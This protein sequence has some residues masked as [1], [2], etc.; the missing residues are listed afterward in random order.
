M[1]DTIYCNISFVGAEALRNDLGE[2]GDDCIISQVV[3]YPWDQNIPLLVEYTE[4]MNRHQPQANIGFVSLEGYMVGK[5]FCMVVEKVDGEL[6]R[7]KFIQ[8]ISDVG[9]FDLGGITLQYGP[10]DHQGM[11]QVFLTIIKDNKIES[12]GAI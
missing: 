6:T 7:E 2:N 9:I 8:T 5:F 1:K 4:A 11:D 10:D 12:L 3:K